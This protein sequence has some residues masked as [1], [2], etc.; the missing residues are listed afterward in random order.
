[1]NKNKYV[2][3]PANTPAL[4]NRS[5]VESPAV[6]QAKLKPNSLIQIGAFTGIYG[7]TTQVYSCSIGRYCSIADGVVI[8]PSEHPTNWLSSSMLQYV[9]NVHGWN[10]YFETTNLRYVEPSKKFQAG[11]PVKIGND[12]WI[13]SGAFIKNG[14]S[15][16]DGAIV[17]AGS[18]VVKDVP[19]YAIV[20]GVP[21]KVIKYRFDKEIID[22]LLGLSWW[23]FNILGIADID[24]S[25]INEAID[26]LYSHK[27]NG[28]LEELNPPRNLVEDIRI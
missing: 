23:N 15:I 13:G 28:T 17:S 5:W 25:K 8:G 11:T 16:G 1:M 7:S 22:S 14:V 24:F 9:K 21:A 20:G 2:T 12:V 27:R 26:K 19:P 3:I 10:E 6:I 18:V 4:H